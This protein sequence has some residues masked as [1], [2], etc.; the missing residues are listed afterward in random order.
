M[1]TDVFLD[2]IPSKTQCNSYL[3]SILHCIRYYCDLD[4][5]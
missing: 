5:I 1:C 3:H 4:M 2:I